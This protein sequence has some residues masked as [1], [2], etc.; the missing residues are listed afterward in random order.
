[1]GRSR[2]AFTLPSISSHSRL[3]WLFEMPLAPI[4]LTRA[5]PRGGD[6]SRKIGRMESV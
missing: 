4:A 6:W 1:M 3:T 2:K 5:C